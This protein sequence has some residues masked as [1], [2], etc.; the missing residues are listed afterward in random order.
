M[1]LSRSA[2]ASRI[3]R[4]FF[5][6]PAIEKTN[7]G[8]A[9]LRFKVKYIA[10]ENQHGR[11]AARIQR[12]ALVASPVNLPQEPREQPRSFASTSET[13]RAPQLMRGNPGHRADSTAS[14]VIGERRASLT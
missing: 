14:Q 5:R 2:V 8:F 7:S 3:D 4:Y 6:S 11:N 9:K 12:I 13:M 10:V 1:R